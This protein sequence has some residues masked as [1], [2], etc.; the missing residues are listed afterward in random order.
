MLKLQIGA[1]AD[2]AVARDYADVYQA[3]DKNLPVYGGLSLD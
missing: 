1:V 3:T 2:V